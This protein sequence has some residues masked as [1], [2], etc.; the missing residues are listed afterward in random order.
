M[1]KVLKYKLQH[2]QQGL[3]YAYA[4]CYLETEP[5]ELK[6]T[7]PRPQYGHEHRRGT[8]FA[9]QRL[10]EVPSCL[11][12][13]GKEEQQSCSKRHVLKFVTHQYLVSRSESSVRPPERASGQP[14]RHSEP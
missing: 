7:T 5:A 6:D 10:W 2:L 8:Q 13:L 3:F 14:V 4:E 9:H 11:V 1:R 12:R